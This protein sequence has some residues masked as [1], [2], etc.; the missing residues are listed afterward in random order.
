MYYKNY[1]KRMRIDVYDLGKTNIILEMLWLQAHNLEINWKI[2]EVK[3]MRYSPMYR[4]RNQRKEKKKA[5]RKK[6]VITLE[7]KKIVRWAID[8]KKN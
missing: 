5:K 1:I 3:M 4:E 7:K 6:R 2:R 8:N